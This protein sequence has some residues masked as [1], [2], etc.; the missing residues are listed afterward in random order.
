MLRE[1]YRK[2]SDMLN[3]IRLIFIDINDVVVEV[4]FHKKLSIKESFKLIESLYCFND[5]Q[6]IRKSDGI[7]VNTLI[8]LEETGLIDGEILYV[9]GRFI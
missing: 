6:I 9:A 8:P 2:L 1:I 7:L 5:Y 4:Y 3:Y